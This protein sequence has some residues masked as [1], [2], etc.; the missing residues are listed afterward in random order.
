MEARETLYHAQVVLLS[1]PSDTS[2]VEIEQEC[3]KNFH[4][5]ARAEEGFLK[6][7]SRIQWLKLGD[8]NSNFFHKVVKARNSKN[9]IKSIMMDNGCK[10]DDPTSIKQEF[11][12]HSQ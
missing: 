1:N 7:K 8:Q 6:I 10:I 12:K 9:S 3:L 2:L 11:V 5:L 4:D